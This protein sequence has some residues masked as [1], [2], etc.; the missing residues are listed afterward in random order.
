MFEYMQLFALYIIGD[1]KAL[2]SESVCVLDQGLL[3]LGVGCLIGLCQGA[4]GGLGNVSLVKCLG[5]ASY[6]HILP[7]ALA[8]IVLLHHTPSELSF[9]ACVMF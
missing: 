3:T 5:E 4:P 7:F 8:L 2:T 1:V 6:R 9:Q